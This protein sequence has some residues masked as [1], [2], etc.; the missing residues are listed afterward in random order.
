MCRERTSSVCSDVIEH[1]PDPDALMRFLVSATG[2]WL[3]LST[4]DRELAYSKS[5]PYQ[6]GPP[7]SDHHMR[8]W[9]MNEFRH[10]V[11]QFAD[12]VEHVHSHLGHSTQTVVAS[13]RR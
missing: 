11:S 9:S 8:E 3:A 2:R 13:P 4:P 10:Y 7:S 12:I 6:L 5:S 1:V